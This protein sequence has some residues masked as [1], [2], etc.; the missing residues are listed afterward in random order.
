MTQ[1][2]DFEARLKAQE[3]A[4]AMLQARVEELSRDMA[5]SFQQQAKYQ[6]AVE[7]ELDIRFR[8][9]DARLDRLEAHMATKGDLA[10]LESK[11]ERRFA[12]LDN[13]LDSMLQMLA[14]VTKKI[15]E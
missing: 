13:K 5:M 9:I 1:S 4:T 12:S 6:G 2:P 14:T 3:H 15:V 10:A 7:R 11:F 8:H